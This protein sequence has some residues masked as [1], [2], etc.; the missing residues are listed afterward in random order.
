MDYK[1][2]KDSIIDTLNKHVSLKRK[3]EELI[4]R[5]S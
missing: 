2:F 1:H 4:I 3:N 5:T